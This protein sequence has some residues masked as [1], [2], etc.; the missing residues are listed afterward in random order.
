ME[1]NQKYIDNISKQERKSPFLVEMD[2]LKKD[3]EVL[4]NACQMAYRKHTYG[5]DSVGWEEL[6][7]ELAQALRDVMGI[8]GYGKWQDEYNDEN[9]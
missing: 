5:D 1:D 8:E 3:K 7:G 6:T 4:L 2:Q 9:E